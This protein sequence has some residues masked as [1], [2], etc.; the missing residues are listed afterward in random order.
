MPLFSALNTS[1][2]AASSISS[3]PSRFLCTSAMWSNWLLVNSRWNFAET[4]VLEKS[5]MSPVWARR[6]KDP[7]EILNVYP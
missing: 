3:F 4:D 1:P 2:A 7:S 6:L 5:K